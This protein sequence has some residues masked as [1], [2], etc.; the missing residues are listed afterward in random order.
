MDVPRFLKYL[1]GLLI[2]AGFARLAIMID[3]G[4]SA[5]A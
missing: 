2:A 3:R 4:I 5:G 1:G